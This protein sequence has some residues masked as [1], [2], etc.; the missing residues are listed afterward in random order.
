MDSKKEHHSDLLLHRH[1][2][3][4][5]VSLPQNTALPKADEENIQESKVYPRVNSLSKDYG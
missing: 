1:M 4:A 3:G 2:Q 5:H